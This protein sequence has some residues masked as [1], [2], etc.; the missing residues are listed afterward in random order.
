MKKK[1]GEIYNKVIVEGDKNL[2]TNNEIHKSE[3]IGESQNESC[4]EEQ[5]KVRI[6]TIKSIDINED[7]PDEI[8]NIPIG[9]ANDNPTFENLIKYEGWFKDLYQFV[10]FESQP[11]SSDDV[12]VVYTNDDDNSG[13]LMLDGEYVQ[14][15]SRIDFT[16][17][18]YMEYEGI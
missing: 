2:V 4:P 16:K 6:L 9:L 14:T 12:R 13:S 7:A 3:L 18:Y 15:N 1:I 8:A 11:F 17:E 10:N 5:Y